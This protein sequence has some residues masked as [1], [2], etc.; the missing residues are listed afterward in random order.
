MREE[1]EGDSSRNSLVVVL[2]YTTLASISAESDNVQTGEETDEMDETYGK[3]SREKIVVD[4]S[5]ATVA[6]TA[7]GL[8]TEDADERRELDR[9]ERG[10]LPDEQTFR[11]KFLDTAAR[12][13]DLVSMHDEKRTEVDH[14]RQ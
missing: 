6:Q 13:A 5:T 7:N 11:A 14:L 2:R 10:L 1:S 12:F 9:Y 4:G 3:D 8:S